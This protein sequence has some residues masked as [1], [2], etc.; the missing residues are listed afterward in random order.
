MKTLL[1]DEAVL[2]KK[3]DSRLLE[4]NVERGVLKREELDKVSAEL[5]DDAANAVTVQFSS[6]F[7]EAGEK[8]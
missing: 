3:F 1:L 6:L 8:R 4:R 2:D 5:P 7:S